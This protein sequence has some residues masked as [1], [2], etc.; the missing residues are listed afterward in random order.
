MVGYATVG[1]WAA[2]PL[3][4]WALTTFVGA[5]AAE[6]WLRE[7]GYDWAANWIAN[8]SD[9]IDK[10]YTQDELSDVLALPKDGDVRVTDDGITQVYN[11]DL[12]KWQTD[13][14]GSYN[15]GVA[16]A[17]ESQPTYS[18][19][20][21]RIR[22]KLTPKPV[23]P[24]TNANNIDI[25]NSLPSQ[26]HVQAHDI[27]NNSPVFDQ[28]ERPQQKAIIE[29]L[30][31]DNV[32]FQNK[33]GLLN[34]NAPTYSGGASLKSQPLVRKNFPT[35]TV[36]PGGATKTRTKLLN[37]PN[38]YSGAAS[39]TRTKLAPRSSVYD[40]GT[41]YEN[42]NNV[43][44]VPPVA[45]TQYDGSQNAQYRDSRV[46]NRITPASN[47][48]VVD[49]NA[50]RT[51][52]AYRTP[53]AVQTNAA[54][55]DARNR[56]V[57]AESTN[58]QP[59]YPNNPPPGMMEA[60]EYEANTKNSDVQVQTPDEQVENKKTESAT[61]KNKK[62]KVNHPPPG[63][64]VLHEYVTYTYDAR[65]SAL[66]QEFYINDE[67]KLASNT[68][69]II[70]SSGLGQQKAEAPKRSGKGKGPSRS[71]QRVKKAGGGA[72]AV[73]SLAP[74][75]QLNSHFGQITLNS[76]MGLNSHTNVSNV[77]GLTFEVFEPYATSLLDDLHDAQVAIGNDN[78]LHSP[79]LLTID[80]H[81]MDENGVPTK[82]I[83]TRYFPIKI[84]NCDFDVS[85]AGTTYNFEAV[86][87][88]ASTMNDNIKYTQDPVTLRGETVRELFDDLETQLN[89]QFAAKDE[90][91]KYFI[92]GGTS[93]DD[94]GGPSSWDI[95]SATIGH[96]ST[97][98]LSTAY[99]PELTEEGRK[100][101]KD[102][103]SQV[104][105]Q[106]GFQDI[107]PLSDL[108]G[109]DGNLTRRTY[110]FNKG[111]AITS[112]IE[113]IVESS[114]Y[115]TKQ[116]NNPEQFVQNINGD[117]Q[118][119]WYNL[120]Y[121][122]SVSEDG[123]SEFSFFTY[124]YMVDASNV[125]NTSTLKSS[126]N[127]PI[128]RAYEYI[129]TGANRDI[130][131]FDIQYNFAFFQALQ[132]LPQQR[133]NKTENSKGK[134]PSRAQQRI[135]KVAEVKGKTPVK[136]ERSISDKSN[137]SAGTESSGEDRDQLSIIKEVLQNPAAD[138]LNLDLEILGDPFYLQQTDFRYGDYA[139]NTTV[140]FTLNDGSIYDKMGEVYVNLSFKTPVDLDDETGLMTGLQG[141]GKYQ[142]AFFSG[143]YRIIGVETVMSQGQFT[144]RLQLV[145]LKNQEIPQ[146]EIEPQASIEGTDGE[147][148]EVEVGEFGEAV[149]VEQGFTDDGS[150]KQMNK[151]KDNQSTDSDV[152]RILGEDSNTTTET[153]VVSEGYTVN[154]GNSKYEG[155]NPNSQAGGGQ[156]TRAAQ[157]A[158]VSNFTTT[159][160]LTVQPTVTTRTTTIQERG[161][162]S[163]IVETEP[164]TKGKNK[165]GGL[166]RRQYYE[167]NAS[168][169]RSRAES[170]TGYSTS[171]SATTTE[172]SGTGVGVG[173]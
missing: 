105:Y 114:D 10:Y 15:S 132:D 25:A 168:L 13:Y 35:N 38:T 166:T 54:Q 135:G 167:R 88:N 82:A 67:L 42:Y 150:N 69:I 147:V 81:G 161:G 52:E 41:R 141:V 43:V 153:V 20:A 61:S 124:S 30:N 151:N 77:H 89:E 46:V 173:R 128:A 127:K 118:V 73:Y 158:G 14:T 143:I 70:R 55:I 36:Y 60:R 162:G 6:A 2:A 103:E 21:K 57:G 145:R 79:Y 170:G 144:Q 23:E 19:A 157:R 126:F 138:L 56:I 122:F 24:I 139:M 48:K 129:Y 8:N 172:N 83:T 125:V 169:S 33:L 159:E 4:R 160:T 137:P 3:I 91:R 104:D 18:N 40:R 78:Y 123:E 47:T 17:I 85:G 58:A 121:K 142:T 148:Q 64:N 108:A 22:K 12:D 86:P 28:I 11:A 152:E 50:L 110:T 120:D 37:Q 102:L 131:S 59:S 29:K 163:T 109:V 7:N 140:P 92:R 107:P 75:S 96:D 165:Y 136:S 146:V 87:F 49:A 155:Y 51:D 97:T 149:D 130:L 9:E 68:N 44:R 101:V 115:I 112:I 39:Q 113:A 111:V 26:S 98:A 34:E 65:L 116:V 94:M 27:V 133:K 66:P 32:A 95:L 171:P 156:G 80:F 16:S 164:E 154:K 72:D 119:P 62:F 53:V 106:Q 84:I 134:G 76:I 1:K 45:T 90:N 74:G 117:G 31:R 63:E 99:A 5:A 93:F 100:Y 71:Q